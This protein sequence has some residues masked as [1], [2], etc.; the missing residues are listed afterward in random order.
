M[1]VPGYG[2]QHQHVPS[3]LLPGTDVDWRG[4]NSKIIHLPS[5]S[6]SIENGVL[7][8]EATRD[9]TYL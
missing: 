8:N 9:E 7:V 1:A 4:I 2:H 6:F 3:E 5:I